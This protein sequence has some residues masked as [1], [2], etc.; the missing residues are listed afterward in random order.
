MKT[1]M[2]K[3]LA[4]VALAAM[5]TACSQYTC[6]TYAKKDIKKAEKKI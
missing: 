1:T 2:K 4:F 6:P 3:A 5:L